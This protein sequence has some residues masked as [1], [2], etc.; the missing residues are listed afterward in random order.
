VK[1]KEYRVSYWAVQ[2]ERWCNVDG[3]VNEKLAEEWEAA[4]WKLVTRVDIRN[5]PVFGEIQFEEWT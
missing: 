2:G 4:G 3:L 5:V 1:T